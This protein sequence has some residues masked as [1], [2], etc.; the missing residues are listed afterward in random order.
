MG[1]EPNRVPVFPAYFSLYANKCANRRKKAGIPK[2]ALYKGG[3]KYVNNV[4]HVDLIRNVTLT[5]LN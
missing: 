3:N 5:L 1:L 4:M 2:D